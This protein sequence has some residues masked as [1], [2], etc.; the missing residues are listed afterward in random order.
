MIDAYIISLC[1][2]S[3]SHVPVCALY[4][5]KSTVPC[6]LNVA[7]VLYHHC[8]LFSTTGMPSLFKLKTS[9]DI[10]YHIHSIAEIHNMRGSRGR[11][12]GVWTLSPMINQQSF[13]VS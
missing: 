3:C 6:N 2:Y 1:L 5:T 11:G 9:Q 13:W 4:A 12:Q 10:S 8:I 7:L